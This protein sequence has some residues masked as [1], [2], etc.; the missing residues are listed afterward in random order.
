MYFDSLSDG[1]DSSHRKGGDFELKKRVRPSSCMP[2]SDIA[3]KDSGQHAVMW[4]FG[5]IMDCDRCPGFG[6]A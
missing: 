2:Q 4:N 5:A 6:F 1:C 3:E